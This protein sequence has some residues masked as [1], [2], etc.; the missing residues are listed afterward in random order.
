MKSSRSLIVAVLVGILLLAPVALFYARHEA[1][2]DRL[3]RDLGFDGAAANAVKHAY[4]AAQVYDTLRMISV[5]ADLAQNTVL[6]LG[7]ANE[8]AERIVKFHKPDSTRELLKDFYNNYAGITTARWRETMGF[9]SS[10][11]GMLIALAQARVLIVTRDQ[12]PFY[13]DAAPL[14]DDTVASAR[15]WFM[16]QQP[17]IQARVHQGLVASSQ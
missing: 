12:N 3:Q 4:A 7:I 8:Y 6:F 11:L 17:A 9:D 14:P 13:D 2:S 15:N 1:L 10:T 5:P 16:A